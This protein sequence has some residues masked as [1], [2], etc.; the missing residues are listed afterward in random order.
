MHLGEALRA[1]VLHLGSANEI[2]RLELSR[3]SDPHFREGCVGWVTDCSRAAT[4][5]GPRHSA[6][7]ILRSSASR[8]LSRIDSWC[9]LYNS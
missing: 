5:Y 8:L 4:L 1:A 3:S 9:Q 6:V 2:E 7:L